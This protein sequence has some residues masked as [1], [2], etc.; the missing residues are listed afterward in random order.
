MSSL[1]RPLR[2][3]LG[4]IPLLILLS[5]SSARAD[6]PPLAEM[7]DLEKAFA[8]SLSGAELVGYST[9]DDKDVGKLTPDRYTIEEA[10]KVNAKQ[11][12]IKAGFKVGEVVL[13]FPLLLDVEWAGD[14]PVITLTDF[15]I[16]PLGT[17]TARVL[18]YR[19][20]YAGTWSHGATDGGN[21]V[22]GQIFGSIVRKGD[23]PP[24]A[25]KKPPGP[26]SE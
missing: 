16:G 2:C 5:L 12:R 11:W 7:S 10:V 13:V 21:V 24:V 14:T 3:A 23:K 1:A 20:R 8:K 9:R 26:A 4:L 22:G 17:F 18:F 19:G 25:E 6:D 15:A